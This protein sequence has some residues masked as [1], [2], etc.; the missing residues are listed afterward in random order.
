M[1]EPPGLPEKEW[2]RVTFFA[3]KWTL[4]PQKTSSTAHVSC[5]AAAV[6]IGECGFRRRSSFTHGDSWPFLTLLV[7]QFQR[8]EK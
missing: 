3:G 5:G 4:H 2:H 7:R 6:V 8:D 1:P